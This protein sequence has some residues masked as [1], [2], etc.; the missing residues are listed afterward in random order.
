MTCRDLTSSRV[1]EVLD[2]SQDAPSFFNCCRMIPPYLS[3]HSQA[4]STIFSRPFNCGLYK[5]LHVALAFFEPFSSHPMDYF[6]LGGHGDMLGH[7]SPAGV[8]SVQP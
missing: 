2:Q 3:V 7:W 4:Y 5:S 8:F 1:K 6:G